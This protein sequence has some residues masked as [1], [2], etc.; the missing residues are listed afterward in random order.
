MGF[1]CLNP[2]V[3]FTT[4]ATKCTKSFR[5]CGGISYWLAS[6]PCRRPSMKRV[7]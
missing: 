4:K 6:Q 5:V 3:E 1:E 7:V 2:A